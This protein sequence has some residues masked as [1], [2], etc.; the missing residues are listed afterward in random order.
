MLCEADLLSLRLFFLWFLRDLYDCCVVC[1]LKH[2]LNLS[3]F[4]TDSA[5]F[6]LLLRYS[7]GLIP[8]RQNLSLTEKVTASSF[9]RF[10]S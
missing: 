1:C 10:L 6:F 3:S 9:C 2:I 7:I 5:F 8:T 4:H